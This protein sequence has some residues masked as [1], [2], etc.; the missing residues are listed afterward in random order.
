MHH[1]L[2]GRRQRA[3]LLG[4]TVATSPAVTNERRGALGWPLNN[5]VEN[6]GTSEADNVS[7][8]EEKYLLDIRIRCQIRAQQADHGMTDGPVHK[9]KGIRYL[10]K[11]VDNGAFPSIGID[12]NDG[13]EA[14][15]CAQQTDG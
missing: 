11:E 14:G 15:Y 8:C 13:E 12:Q 6:V 9:I 7:E 2:P 1:V 3:R 5:E 10:A 4:A